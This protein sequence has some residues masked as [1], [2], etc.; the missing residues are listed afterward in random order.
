MF[1]GWGQQPKRGRTGLETVVAAKSLWAVAFA[2]EF[3]TASI[4]RARMG[5]EK[6]VEAVRCLC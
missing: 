1:L 3:V 4:L 5:R 2:I 6:T